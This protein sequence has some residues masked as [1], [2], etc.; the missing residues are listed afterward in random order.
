MST[1]F[2]LPGAHRPDG[3]SSRIPEWLVALNPPGK[4]SFRL[5]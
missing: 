4:V 1:A 5:L 2:I 3:R